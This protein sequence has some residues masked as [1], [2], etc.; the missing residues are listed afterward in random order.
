MECADTWSMSAKSD[1][2]IM[3]ATIKLKTCFLTVAVFVSE[4][5]PDSGELFLGDYSPVDWH[6]VMIKRLVMAVKCL[7]IVANSGQGSEALHFNF[8]ALEQKLV[9]WLGN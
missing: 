9:V 5:H 2:A 1:K 6:E 7:T 8:G 3:N 4:C